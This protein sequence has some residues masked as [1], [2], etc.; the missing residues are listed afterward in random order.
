MDS[1]YVFGPDGSPVRTMEC[2]E[3]WEGLSSPG[4]RCSPRGVA[5][6]A[7]GN[8][9][10]ADSWNHRVQVFRLDGTFVRS[11]GSEGSGPG[12]M[13]KPWGV[14]V[15]GAG[16]ILVSER[17]NH[18]V[19]VFGVDGSAVRSFGSKGSGPGQLCRPRG[20]ALD[21]D[22]GV[23]VADWGNDRVQVFRPDGTAASCFGAAGW[24]PSP[25]DVAVNA[26]GNV[27]VADMAGVHVLGPDG[28]VVRS[29][30][31]KCLGIPMEPNFGVAV[32]GE[33]KILVADCYNNRVLIF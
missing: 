15:D 13:K 24:R 32:D 19:Q 1:V 29:F 18:R 11:F 16:Q 22:G 7:E 30:E 25:C 33:G 23:V 2:W 4:K 5:L 31:L 9:V 28:S 26:D 21:R 8:V 6:D 27:V 14:A 12:Q 10:V 3:D 17:G 20:I